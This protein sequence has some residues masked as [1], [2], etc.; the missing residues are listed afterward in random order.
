M[1][2]PIADGAETPVEHGEILD[3]VHLGPVEKAVYGPIGEYLEAHGWVEGDLEAP[4]AGATYYPFAYDWRLDNVATAARLRDTLDRI[5]D[6]RGEETLVFD[7]VCQS[8]GAHVC[9]YLLKYGGESLEEA[10]AGR[11]GLPPRFRVRKLVLIGASNG[12][13]LRIFRMLDRGRRYLGALGRLWAP[14]TMFTFPS[15]FQDLPGYRED[16]FVNE[17]GEP[18]GA[19]LWDPEDWIRYGW[20]I[21]DPESE[22][23]I[24]DSPWAD[25]FG[26]G[27]DRRAWLAEQLDRARRFQRL[28]AADR[29]VGSTRYYVVLGSFDPTP[30]RAVLI[31][32]DE[33]WRTLVFGDRELEALP[34]LRRLLYAPG[35]DH[36]TVASVWHLS[37]RERAAVAAEPLEVEGGHF[38]I[39]LHPAT[40][41]NLVGWLTD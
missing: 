41:E 36:A 24:R 34:A 4:S 1:A 35:D 7:L 38:E 18:Q 16:L 37:P 31:R 5:R 32:G 17:E 3:V 11:A 10:E 40:L 6:A 14:E 13:S 20:S 23:A 19:S 22:A 12:G 27:S 29:D 9:R 2:L 28:L 8:N 21:F 25:R 26:D 39:V 15:F 33:G 30:D